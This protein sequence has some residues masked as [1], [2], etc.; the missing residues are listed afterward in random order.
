MSDSEV[1]LDLVPAQLYRPKLLRMAVIAVTLG[2]VV[3]LVVAVFASWWLAAAIGLFVAGPT[4][5]YLLLLSRRRMWLTQHVVHNRR[6]F[7]TVRTRLDRA[8]RAELE[9]HP[10]AIGQITLTVSDGATSQT[11]PLAMYTDTGSGREL[12]AAALRGLA[13]G[14]AESESSAAA[15]VSA[16][17]AEQAQVG[18]AV[19]GE[20]PLF[21]AYLVLHRAGLDVS[22]TLTPAELAGLLS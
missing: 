20:R 4:T 13:N 16:V 18:D 6:F 19:L 17:L 1:S 11:V 22:H 2:A 9:V 3:A 14:L 7:A 8:D 10:G 5:V 15:A 21:R 12:D